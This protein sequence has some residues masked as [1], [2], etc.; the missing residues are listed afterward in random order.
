MKNK[1][2]FLKDNFSNIM[3]LLP[4]VLFQDLNFT[5]VLK[6]LLKKFL[7]TYKAK[8]SKSEIKKDYGTKFLKSP[9]ML[10]KIMSKN[11]MR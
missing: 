4:N 10:R 5:I 3:K 2:R 8:P 7:L 6:N 11:K 9:V 1:K